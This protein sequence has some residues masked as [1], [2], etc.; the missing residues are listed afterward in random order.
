MAT[1]DEL[2]E[3]MYE[4]IKKKGINAEDCELE[5]GYNPVV[6]FVLRDPE[7]G[8]EVEFEIDLSD[9]FCSP[10]DIPLLDENIEYYADMDE[11]IEARADNLA[12]EY[13]S[14]NEEDEDED[15]EE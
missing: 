4:E 3:K 5:F 1:Y 9:Y 10:H 12:S 15:E 11:L 6:P 14:E 2:Y 8:A 13:A 7:S